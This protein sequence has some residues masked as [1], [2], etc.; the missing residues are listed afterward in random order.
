MAKC[1][2]DSNEGAL[3]RAVLAGLCGGLA[4]VLWV[5]GYASFSPLSGEEVARQI[6]AS[7]IPTAADS[8]L[9]VAFGISI[10]FLLSVL[11]G[12]AFAWLVWRPFLKGRGVAERLL[13]P[14]A[15]LTLVWGVNFFAVL[16]FLN[17]AFV[18]LMPYGVTLASKI[19]FGFVMGL[20]LQ[21][22]SAG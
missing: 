7:V 8:A 6:T 17:P 3:Q 20:V 12:M 1:V 11:L 21:F 16:P 4:E 10:H 22:G 9:A 13:G 19:M 14:V 18:V 2:S 5:A 15:V